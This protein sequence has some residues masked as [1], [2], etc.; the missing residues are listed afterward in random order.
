MLG[1][2][3]V[4]DVVFGTTSEARPAR[5]TGRPL[6]ILLVVHAIL[7][8]IGVASL[9]YLATQD[10]TGLICFLGAISTGINSGASGLVVAHELGHRRKNTLPWWIAKVNLLSTLYLHF[11]TE[12]NCTHHKHVG[13]TADP[14]T[15]E[16]GE[17]VWWFI[18]RTIPGQFFDA[19]QV[20]R[21][22]TRS[23]LKNQV[24]IGVCIQ[25]VLLAFIWCTLGFKPLFAFIVQAGFA[26]FL[27]E[28]INYIRH[29]G[30]HRKKGERLT[31]LHSWQS[32]HRWSR[33]TLLELTRHP[34]HH[35]E[36]SKPFWKLQPNAKAPQLPS[37]YYGCFW[38]ALIPTLWRRVVDPLIP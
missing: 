38:I 8:I 31:A 9:L 5:T 6:E 22:R 10:S 13:T 34:A 20:Q 32:E 11:S 23:L 25:S 26:I 7:Q 12:H 21:H 35:L 19:W 15:A 1:L 36:A 17:S 14:A 29:Y 37:G 27:L 28:Y 30:L 18:M 2:G 3:P 33:W 4:L 16:R 24:F